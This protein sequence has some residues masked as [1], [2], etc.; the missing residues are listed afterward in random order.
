MKQQEGAFIKTSIPGLETAKERLVN[1]GFLSAIEEEGEEDG[2]RL[3]EFLSL[4]GKGPQQ[5]NVSIRDFYD[6]D[7]HHVLYYEAKEDEDLWRALSRPVN[8]SGGFSS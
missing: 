8:F 1:R 2:Q 5:V 3:T 7:C 4:A 6:M